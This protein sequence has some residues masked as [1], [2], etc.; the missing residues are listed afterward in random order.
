MNDLKVRLILT[1][2]ILYLFPEG[3]GSRWSCNKWVESYEIAFAN[4]N[5]HDLPASPTLGPRTLCPLATLPA[6]HPGFAFSAVGIQF[7]TIQMWCYS[8]TSLSSCS[9]IFSRFLCALSSLNRLVE[10]HFATPRFLS[11]MCCL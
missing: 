1:V 5:V 6:L 8:F 11:C 4:Y 9:L 2:D 10:R 7:R 3:K